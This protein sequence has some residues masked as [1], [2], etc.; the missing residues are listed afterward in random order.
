MIAG[1]PMLNVDNKTEN[2]SPGRMDTWICAVLAITI[3]CSAAAYSFRL[4]SFLL[5]KEAVL[6]GGLCVIAALGVIRGRMPLAGCRAFFPLWSFLSL[7]AFFHLGLAQAQVP[8]DTTAQLIRGILLLCAAAYAYDLL[9]HPRF[10]E[11]IEMTLILS[12]VSVAVLGI[13]QYMGLLEGMFPVFET[14]NQPAY[15]VFGNQDYLGGYLAMGI[16]LLVYRF[17]VR[18]RADYFALLSMLILLGGLLLTGSRSAWLAAIIGVATSLFMLARAVKREPTLSNLLPK[19]LLLL[20]SVSAAL[21]AVTVSMA[22]ETTLQ[23]IAM[24]FSTQDKGGTLRL[25]FW[26]GTWRMFQDAPF[27]GKGLGNY[28]YWSPHYLG[29]ALH[30]AGGN[31]HAHNTVHTLHAHCDPLEILAETG[32]LGALCWGW[33]ALRLLRCR[34]PEWG[35]LAALLAFSLMNAAFYSISHALAGL[36]LAGMLLA[37]RPAKPGKEA[38]K[39]KR[40]TA[41]ALAAITLLSAAFI[42]GA[43]VWPSYLLQRAFDQYAGEEPCLPAFEEAA[44]HP[45]PNA[46]AQQ[47]YGAALAENGQLKEAYPHLL[48]ALKGCDTGTL[49]LALGKLA[50]EFGDTRQART[51]LE[52]CLWRWPSDP[53]AWNLLAEIASASEYERLR[54]RAL[55]WNVM[56]SE[57]GT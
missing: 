7:A 12:M 2:A 45:W 32:L 40:T 34:G 37:R 13:L 15:S 23:R 29:E 26:D 11:R 20:A 27:I 41:Y 49:Y 22:P 33:M 54:L 55:Q 24:T 39:N 16:P 43:T 10:R 42:L 48:N 44:R 53:V 1:I 4:T 28:A 8:A 52:A 19:R 36:L 30:A 35:A 6:A 38:P 18:P 46:Y 3:L 50:I 31:L 51:W 56:L 25:W 9:Q 14:Y 17:L 57:S 21:I 47:E 5:A